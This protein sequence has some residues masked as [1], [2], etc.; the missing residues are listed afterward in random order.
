MA[1]EGIQVADQGPPERRTQRWTLVAVCATTFMLLVD[2]TIV[3]VALPSIQRRLHP[4][5]TGLQWVVDAYAITLAAL[6]LTAGALADRYG[7]RL[8]FTAG[9]VI[10]STASL[11]CGLAWNIASLDV[12]RALQGVGGAALFATALALIGA[13]YDGLARARAIAVWGSTVGLAVASGP[14]VGGILTDSLGWRWI[15]FVNVPIGAAAA[16]LA[17]TRV[18]ESR[19]ANARRTDVLGLVTLAASLFLIVFALLRG[20][21]AGWTSGQILGSLIA[22]IAL[23][24]AFVMVEHMQDRP[25]LDISLFRQPVFVGVQLAT[26]CL[27]AGMFA[28][29]P[30][31]S[32]Y[33]QDIDGNTPLGAGLRFLPITAFVFLVPLV[34]RKLATTA[35]MWTLLAS[36]LAIVTGGLLLMEDISVGS[37]WTALLPGFI[38]CGLG[39][40]LANPTIAAAALRVV[41]P[42]R[43]GMASG[44]SNTSRIAG[45]AMGVAALGAILQQHIG[46]R[47]GSEGVHRAGLAQAVS[48]SGLRAAHGNQVLAQAANVA[49]V[50]G[51]R[52]VLLVGAATVFVGSL[53]AVVLVRRRTPQPAP[54]PVSSG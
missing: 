6:I 31:L 50:S 27:G 23:L 2:I 24:V 28:L 17:V 44:I 49:F 15:F 16:W 35:P 41:D 18:R 39:I 11:L 20:N 10:F 3:N 34:T 53:A 9:I 47:L 54:M 19:D 4:S 37:S 14:L 1:S 48:S 5:L 25:M 21:N 13:E 32:I 40:G 42:A 22:G 12:A 8:V 36:S 7:R 29:F 30:F 43:T 51:F 45:L 26:F 33:L 46:A 38:V 52:L